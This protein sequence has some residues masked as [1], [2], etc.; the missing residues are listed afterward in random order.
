MNQPTRPPGLLPE[1]DSITIA[2]YGPLRS[3]SPGRSRQPHLSF[4]PVAGCL[5][6][7]EM[8]ARSAMTAA[9]TV[10]AQRA[11]NEQQ[12]RR[13]LFRFYAISLLAFS[14]VRA[15][16]RSSSCGR[17]GSRFEAC[18]HPSCTP[19]APMLRCQS[20]LSLLVLLVGFRRCGALDGNHCHINHHASKHRIERSR[21]SKSPTTR[22]TT[23]TYAAII[24]TES[25]ARHLA[26]SATSKTPTESDS[27]RECERAQQRSCV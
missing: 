20:K 6:W 27:A 8:K 25:V 10:P 17:D 24:N 4:L 22:T 18:H 5:L 7:E 2:R 9:G 1:A 14:R 11:S 12:Q 23:T 26:W 13:S 16:H 3:S 15:L 21:P 19:Q